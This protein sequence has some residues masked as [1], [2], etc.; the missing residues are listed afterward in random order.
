[1]TAVRAVTAVTAVMCD[2]N[3]DIDACAF[4][5]TDAMW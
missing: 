3:D 5:S 2:G 4:V 1:M